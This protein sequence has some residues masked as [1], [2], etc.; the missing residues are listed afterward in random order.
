MLEQ[1]RTPNLNQT[2]YPGWCLRF[3]QSAYGVP[4][5][6]AY[7]WDQ[8]V[9]SKQRTDPLPDKIVPVYF[10][11]HGNIDGVNQNWGDT[12]IWVPGRGVFGTPLRGGGMSNRWD[13]DVNRRAA[14]IGGN[15]RYVGWSEDIADVLVVQ[16]VPDPAQP[17]AP[18]P[19]QSSQFVRIFGDYRTLY[20]NPDANAFARLAPNN[21]PPKHLDYK[22][23]D[24][25]GNFVKIQTQM[26]GIGWIYVGPDVANL[27]QY[28]NA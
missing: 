9:H 19:T 22:V 25:A 4:H 1:V 8:W 3:T 12:A 27:T 28:F 11:W 6:Y 23:L 18:Q 26:F 5:K 21:Y 15:G 24:R 16:T 20:A 10:E 7:A 14:V 13:S 2:D 17:S